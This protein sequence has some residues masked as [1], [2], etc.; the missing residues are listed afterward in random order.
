MRCITNQ[1]LI[2]HLAPHVHFCLL[3]G[4]VFYLVGW[5]GAVD[6]GPLGVGVWVAR[7]ELQITDGFTSHCVNVREKYV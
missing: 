5:D 7:A 3:D 2:L 1:Y 6:G 4:S